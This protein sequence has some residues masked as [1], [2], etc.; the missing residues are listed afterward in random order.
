MESTQVPQEEPQVLQ[1][2]PQVPQAAQQ[3]PK[4]PELPRD[5]NDSVSDNKRSAYADDQNVVGIALTL[6]SFFLAAAEDEK[7]HNKSL[8]GKEG[9]TA[10]EPKPP[11][12]DLELLS[13]LQADLSNLELFTSLHADEGESVIEKWVADSSYLLCLNL[14]RCTPPTTT[15]QIFDIIHTI[16]HCVHDLMNTVYDNHPLD[17]KKERILEAQAQKEPNDPSQKLTPR[18]IIHLGEYLIYE[19]HK[20]SDIFHERYSKTKNLSSRQRRE[21][22]CQIKGEEKKGFYNDGSFSR[23][24]LETIRENTII[25]WRFP[26][27]MTPKNFECE[28]YMMDNR[29]GPFADLIPPPSEKQADASEPDVE[30]RSVVD[31]ADS[32][33]KDEESSV[34]E[35]VVPK[36]TGECVSVVEPEEK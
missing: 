36:S 7:T 1:G 17:I 20:M 27:Y 26:A 8:E 6:R 13:Y 33:L 30:G 23:C 21:P 12:F 10:E 31:P 15:K 18:H 2:E 11:V 4:Q 9:N 16:D 14:E 35:E 34:V 28:R 29:L 32:N 25:D 3:D 5:S 24:L 22:Y 19:L